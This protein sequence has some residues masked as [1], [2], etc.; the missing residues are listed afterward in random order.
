MP[1][2]A[3]KND[4]EYARAYDRARSRA[5]KALREAHGVEFDELFRIEM[6][7]EGYVLRRGRGSK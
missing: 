5:F 7:A 2:R 3:E 6:E 4:I 1:S